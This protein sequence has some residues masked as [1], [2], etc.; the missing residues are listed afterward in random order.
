MVL[1]DALSVF[2]KIAEVYMYTYAHTRVGVV[3]I[4]LGGIVHSSSGNV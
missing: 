4:C 3:C 1:R 2:L